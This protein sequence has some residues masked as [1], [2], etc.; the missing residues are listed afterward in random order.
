VNGAE[1]RHWNRIEERT[2]SRGGDGHL[3]KDEVR[4]QRSQK[5]EGRMEEG[6]GIH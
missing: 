2:P 4:K 6:I 1:N 5:S 3:V